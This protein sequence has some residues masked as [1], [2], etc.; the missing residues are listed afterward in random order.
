[1]SEKNDPTKNQ[2]QN[3]TTQNPT[4][5]NPNSNSNPNINNLFPIELGGGYARGCIQ[6]YY[7]DPNRNV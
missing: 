7:N 2:T 4:T 5:Q 6:D 3:P 1:M